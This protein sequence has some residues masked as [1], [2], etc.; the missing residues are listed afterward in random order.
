MNKISR[1]E[2]CKRETKELFAEPIIDK[3]YC[4]E[5]KNLLHAN[6][7]TI[8]DEVIRRETHRIKYG[9]EVAYPK[10]TYG[11]DKINADIE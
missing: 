6:H 10:G 1:C 11:N 3:L 9:G 4:F 7:G 8:I 5:C 2:K